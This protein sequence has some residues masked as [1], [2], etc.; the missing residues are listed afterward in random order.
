MNTKQC[1]QLR[2][3]ARQLTIGMQERKLIDSGHS[4]GRATLI[5]DPSTTR[6]AYRRL[7]RHVEKRRA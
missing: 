3:A 1:K 2:N 4:D 5:N 7:K 6:S